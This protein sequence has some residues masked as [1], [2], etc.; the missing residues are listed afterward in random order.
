MFLFVPVGT[1]AP[2]YHWPFATI[3][4]IAATVLGYAVQFFVPVEVWENYV[5]VVG[6]GIQPVQWLTSLFLSHN[7]IDV[8]E[9]VLFLWAFGL[10]VEGKV[11]ALAM[12]GMF[13][14]VGVAENAVEQVAFLY[15]DPGYS[16]S[17]A[18]S[19]SALMAIAMIWAPVNE[20]NCFYVYWFFLRI[21]S[22]TKEVRVWVFAL[23]FVILRLIW[24][25]VAA[26]MDHT[27]L[28]IGMLGPVVGTGLGL[29]IG[30]GTVKSG[31]VDCEGWDLFTRWK[32]DRELARAW[33]R[34]GELHERSRE[35]AHRVGGGGGSPVLS[36]SR[37]ES[38]ARTRF[39]RM[40]EQGMAM[41]ALLT[42]RKAA[43]N[44]P[45][46][47]LDEPDHLNLIKLL[48]EQREW[49]ESIP[50]MREYVNWNPEKA[51]RVRVRM[52][53]VLLRELKR[54]A[55][56][57]RVL[58]EL[59]PGPLQPDLESMRRKLYD[60]AWAQVDEGVLELEGDA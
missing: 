54:P 29:A 10:I 42:H 43:A 2:L 33:K 41:P 6:E 3:G 28:L 34:R 21:G 26:L 38:D 36:D 14:G 12:L 55:A 9:N 39:A 44:V 17:S 18:T 45:G 40:L 58:E 23:V 7:L 25:A 50:L 24:L 13:L 27:T 16:M 59:P 53:Q 1:D 4:L 22:G 49:A 8:I 32:K 19:I 47:T 56:A 20:L 11:G 52:A 5:N 30:I 51:T 48:H 15:G 37:R 57:L 60:Q 31:L 35:P 46:W